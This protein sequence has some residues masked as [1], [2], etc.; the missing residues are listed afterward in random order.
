MPLS[1]DDL[2]RGFISQPQPIPSPDGDDGD[3]SVVI[4]R[5]RNPRRKVEAVFESLAKNRKPKA[6]RSRS[7]KR[8]ADDTVN[9]PLRGSHSKNASKQTLKVLKQ[10]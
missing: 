6:S 2:I 9:R 5:G 10:K 3:V 7:S 4:L 1:V 8:A